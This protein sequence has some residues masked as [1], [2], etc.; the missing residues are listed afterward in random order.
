MA[1]YIP[2]EILQ[3]FLRSYEKDD[4]WQVHCGDRWLT[5]WVYENSQIEHNRGLPVHRRMREEYYNL[6]V[7]YLELNLTNCDDIDL[8]F[9][10]KEDFEAKYSGSWQFYYT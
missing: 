2:Q 6:A 7:K 5:V 9:N 1:K 3:P 4:V 10:S 8:S